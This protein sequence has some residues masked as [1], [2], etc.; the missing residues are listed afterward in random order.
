[1]VGRSDSRP[2]GMEFGSTF[3][4]RVHQLAEGV[5][6]LAWNDLPEVVFPLKKP[7]TFDGKVERVVATLEQLEVAL[8]V[9]ADDAPVS[10]DLISHL[11]IPVTV[12]QSNDDPQT[13][14]AWAIPPETCENGG[15][16][17]PCIVE[18]IL[19]GDDNGRLGDD[20]N[21]ML[22]DTNVMKSMVVC[23][24]PNGQ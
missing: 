3:S 5:R 6:L 14:E 2:V 8:G 19:M 1:M 13:Y 11:K 10:T 22:L 16:I 12:V 20:P 4:N 21:A 9:S 24:P 18:D 7:R 23:M 15:V 17:G